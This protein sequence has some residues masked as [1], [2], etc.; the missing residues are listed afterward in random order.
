MLYKSLAQSVGKDGD[1]RMKPERE[2]RP[3]AARN[4]VSVKAAEDVYGFVSISAPELGWIRA[5]QEP[6][7]G[8]D[9]SACHGTLRIG[10]DDY[11]ERYRSLD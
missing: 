11:R 10:R 6:V 1:Y 8:L 2:D 4:R 7:N 9:R 5:Q 3:N